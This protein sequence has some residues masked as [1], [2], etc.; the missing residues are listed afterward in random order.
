MENRKKVLYVDDERTNLLVFKTVIGRDYE[1]I[2]VEN[3]AKGLEVLESD[4]EIRVVF[5]DMRMPEMT[6]LEFIKEACKRFEGKK[7]YVLSGF[8]TTDEIQDAL[9]SNLITAYFQKPADFQKIRDA[10]DNS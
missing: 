5:S 4:P 3:G 7:F 1:V 8:D 10:I 9:D 6:G 2:T